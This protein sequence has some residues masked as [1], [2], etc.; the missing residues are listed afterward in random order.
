MEAAARGGELDRIN[1]KA[2]LLADN[3]EYLTFEASATATEELLRRLSTVELSC[4]EL[5]VTCARERVE[6]IRASKGNK[7]K[8]GGKEVMWV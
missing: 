8:Q 5:K 6:L 1:A 4:A 3:K 7:G 2:D